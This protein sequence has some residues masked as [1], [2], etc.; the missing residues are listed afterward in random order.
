MGTSMGWMSM[1]SWGDR[2]T[3]APP[4]LRQFAST[5]A[6]PSR[7]VTEDTPADLLEGSMDLTVILPAGHN[8]NMSVHR[9]TPMMD[10][11]IQVTTAH[12]INPGGHVIHVVSDNRLLSY[13]PS[14][15]IGTLDTTV[16]QIIPKNKVNS[17]NKNRTHLNTQA[18]E[19]NV[20]LKPT[21]D[22]VYKQQLLVNLPRNQLAVY[23]VPPK[24]KI[25]DVL[26]LVCKEKGFDINNF[27]I[28]HPVNIDEKLRGVCSLSDYQLQEVTVVPRDYRAPPLSVTD[29]ITMAAISHPEDKK[30][31]GI[32]SIFSR[33]TKT[34]STGDSSLSSGSAGERS[35]SPARSDESGDG[36][37]PSNTNRPLSHASSSTTL[38][39]APLPPNRPRK[40][41]APAVPPGKSNS[42][43][44]GKSD[45]ANNRI[46]IEKRN[47]SALSRNSSNSSD[48]RSSL[49][50]GVDSD[51]SNSDGTRPTTNLTSVVSTSSLSLISRGKRRAPVPPKPPPAQDENSRPSAIPEE[52]DSVHSLPSQDPKLVQ[53]SR[54]AVNGSSTSSPPVSQAEPVT[55][56]PSSPSSSSFVSSVSSLSSVEQQGP[57]AGSS[58]SAPVVAPQQPADSNSVDPPPPPETEAPPPPL[59]DNEVQSRTASFSSELSEE[60]QGSNRLMNDPIHNGST[61]PKETEAPDTHNNIPEI[62]ESITLN[63]IPKQE[64]IL[65]GL[66]IQINK[67]IRERSCSS[68]S[69]SSG[70]SYESTA[71]KESIVQEF[72]SNKNALNGL[73]VVDKTN[74]VTN[75]NELSNSVKKKNIS[76]HEDDECDSGTVSDSSQ[77]HDTVNK[78]IIKP[79]VEEIIVKELKTEILETPLP[80]VQIPESD[81]KHKSSGILSD[82]KLILDK[83][84]SASSGSRKDSVSSMSS[85]SSYESSNKIEKIKLSAQRSQELSK[86]D[87]ESQLQEAF[88]NLDDETQDETTNIQDVLTQKEISHTISNNNHNNDSHN[89]EYKIPAPPVGFKDG[90]N[91]DTSSVSSDSTQEGHIR[92]H[93]DLNESQPSSFTEAKNPTLIVETNKV[94]ELP[95]PGESTDFSSYERKENKDIT[96]QNNIIKDVSKQSVINELKHTLKEA[97]NNEPRIVDVKPKTQ[98]TTMILPT[99]KVN[100]PTETKAHRKDSVNSVSSYESCGESS[101]L[102]KIVAREHRSASESSYDSAPPPIPEMTYPED[103][104]VR[105]SRSSSI[106]STNSAASS[107]KTKPAGMNFSISTYTTRAEEISYDKKIV[108]SESFSH[109]VRPGKS[110]LSKAESFTAQYKTDFGSNVLTEE[111]EDVNEVPIQSYQTNSLITSESQIRSSSLGRVSSFNDKVNSYNSNKDNFIKPELPHRP[112]RFQRGET[113]ESL[114]RT[115][116]MVNLSHPQTNLRRAQSDLDVTEAQ[117][118]P[119]TTPVVNMHDVQHIQEVLGSGIRD[120]SM[121]PM[122]PD[123]RLAEE[124]VKLQQDFFRWQQQLLQNQHLLHSR[125]APLASNPPSLQSVGVLRDIMSQSTSNLS[126]SRGNEKL[127]SERVIDVKKEHESEENNSEEYQSR[128]GRSLNRPWLS[129]SVQDIS[130]GT[131]E[132][133]ITT[134]NRKTYTS[135]PTKRWVEEPTVTVGAWGERPSQA[136]GVQQVQQDKDHYTSAPRSRSTQ[137]LSTAY[138]PEGRRWTPPKTFISPQ[139][140]SRSQ[141]ENV[142]YE[143]KPYHRNHQPKIQPQSNN[144]DQSAGEVFWKE[145]QA[146]RA[147][148]GL[149]ESEAAEEPA[150]PPRRTQ[151]HLV[152]GDNTDGHENEISKPLTYFGQSNGPSEPQTYYYNGE[153]AAPSALSK[154]SNNAAVSRPREVESDLSGARYTSVV[155]LSSDKSSQNQGN[156]APKDKVR[157]VVQL[158][159]SDHRPQ[160]RPNPIVR[161][162]RQP[163]VEDKQGAFQSRIISNS[164]N[165]QQTSQPNQ[166]RHKSPPPLNHGYSAPQLASSASYQGPTASRLV[167]AATGIA[168][169]DSQTPSGAKYSFPTPSSQVNSNAES[170]GTTFP[171]VKLRPVTNTSPRT[172]PPAEVVAS[173]VKS[174]ISSPPPAP[175]APVAPPPPPPAASAP[176]SGE[177]RTASGKRIM[178]AKKGPSL[179]PREELMMAIRNAAGGGTLKKTRGN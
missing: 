74:L 114:E 105:A 27:E 102:Q 115:A 2:S 52:T 119:S 13:K 118:Q 28:R 122:M 88:A 174:S 109:Q 151:S 80:V 146:R 36:R 141:A 117:K 147:A 135:Q 49:L 55:S 32:F 137:D 139:P 165:I 22:Y 99:K 149:Q 97:N 123:S 8:V 45:H 156:S 71:R 170:A 87:I 81:S 164:G 21:R 31:K 159:N 166:V 144:T 72:N 59:L 96:E 163:V 157:S 43:V 121:V 145:L 83:Q 95:T 126:E 155:T 14:T 143:S 39:N 84:P 136:V 54:V 175:P 171:L 67:N 130:G 89:Y 79:K 140:F 107:A 112:S 33:K 24:T 90:S 173:N 138:I 64:L 19:K 113:S 93:S 1:V 23:R 30:R 3:M 6:L 12:K 161:G 120:P 154:V 98:V 158:N 56:S 125:V 116:S 7:Y 92:T 11:L 129:Q 73:D 26:Q 168:L 94:V 152:N 167:S 41:Q 82:N 38:C 35:V 132:S 111:K 16:I 78:P 153:K 57:A 4:P 50:S 91:D 160:L 62:K 134:S 34:S 60:S 63:Q 66:D 85:V 106:S 148:F 40:R 176:V 150:R 127:K 61:T 46:E 76:K 17:T 86:R 5:S 58:S 178:P 172:S 101:D 77:D 68:V 25:S 131:E 18:I 110:N 42:L 65:P 177:R 29:L 75:I 162:F 47:G 9:S 15:P 20:R 108:K 53:E 69:T 44:N 104:E 37:P 51:L 128:G 103:I 169:R 124:F 70:S 10:L 133:N 179:D 142:G 100:Y 48:Q